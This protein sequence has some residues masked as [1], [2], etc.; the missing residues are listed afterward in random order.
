MWG[1]RQRIHDRKCVNTGIKLIGFE[2]IER[3]DIMQE[4]KVIEIVD[5]YNV[6]IDYG[7]DKDAVQGKKLRI[8]SKGEEIIDKATGS[9]LGT[10]DAIKAV[11]SVKTVY[12]KF[13]LC[14][15][16]RI[17]EVPILSPLAELVHRSSREER[18]PVDPNMMTHRKIPE[19]GVIVVGDTALLLPN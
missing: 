11:V 10:L 2:E 13:S 5:E 4:Y 18:L 3:T 12:A 9:S 16:V 6:I 7:F 17:S 14:H 15:R 8:I 19:G 1:L